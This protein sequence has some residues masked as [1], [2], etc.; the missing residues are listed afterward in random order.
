IFQAQA[1]QS[2]AHTPVRH[3]LPKASPAAITARTPAPPT[4]KG[5]IPAGIPVGSLVK[6]GTPRSSAGKSPFALPAGATPPRVPR[7]SPRRHPGRGL[8][9]AIVM[10]AGVLVLACV[11]MAVY[12]PRLLNVVAP[13]PTPA[14]PG[15]DGRVASRDKT[16]PEKP[17]AKDKGGDHDKK[18]APDDS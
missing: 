3:P 2:P 13:A 14:D 17:P 7:S 4:G 5:P 10:G 15:K 6:P 16:P 1:R 11:G 18:P 12:G 8:W 9:K